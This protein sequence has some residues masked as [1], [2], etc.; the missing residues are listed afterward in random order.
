MTE[1]EAAEKIL[2]AADIIAQKRI[3][4]LGLNKIIVC[5]ITNITNRTKGEYGVTMENTTF[6]AYSVLDTYNLNDRVYVLIPNGDYKK[7]K[8]IIG[9][10][11]GN[12]VTSIAQTIN[13][14][15]ENY[16]KAITTDKMNK[17]TTCKIVDAVGKQNGEYKVT[18][19][20]TNNYTFNAYSD[21]DVYNV[22]DLVYVLT[23]YSDDSETR[24]I[25]G[26]KRVK[27]DN[28]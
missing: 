5:Q 27:G 28:K 17:I 14:I 25:L 6:K 15:V 4:Q 13:N 19:L 16:F 24:L 18:T 22:D 3:G 10:Q 23:P 8:I 7:T 20:G 26:R 1:N 12:Q 21:L 11:S 2:Q 9:Y